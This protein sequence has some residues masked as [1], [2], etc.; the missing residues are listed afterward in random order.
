LVSA[1]HAG[2][3]DAFKPTKE[4]K[5]ASSAAAA[6]DVDAGP[7]DVGS[8]V[9]T[10]MTAMPLGFNKPSSVNVTRFPQLNMIARPEEVVGQPPYYIVVTR[11]SRM[12]SVE[13]SHQP[14]LEIMGEYLKKWVKKNHNLS[15][16]VYILFQSLGASTCA[17]LA[18]VAS[19]GT[20]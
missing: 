8:G 2:L 17:N 4:K 1:F 3:L 15:S 9:P 5:S 18:P 10:T 16:K 19:Y 13:C 20:Y 14:G 7:S 12:F 6:T 11:S